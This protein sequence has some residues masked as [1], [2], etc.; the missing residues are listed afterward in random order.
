MTQPVFRFAPSPNGELHCGHALSALLNFQAARH[1]DGRFLLRI[2]DIDLGRARDAYV[3]QIFDDLSW[4]GLIWEEPVRRQS[5]HMHEYAGAVD[6][7]AAMGLTYPCFCTRQEIAAAASGS[8]P[9][10][11]PS[12][13]GTCRHL[14]EA[15][16]RKATANGTPFA[17]R[18]DMAAALTRIGRPL[19]FRKT[20]LEAGDEKQVQADPARWGDVVIA[21]K[22]VPTSYH[23][24][25]VFD[26]AL[27][28]V[29]HIV[30]GMDL[31]ASTDVHRV[32]QS[33]LKFPEPV[34]SHHRLILGEDGRKLA[35]S[36]PSQS[37]RALREGGATPADII[38]MV[39]LEPGT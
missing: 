27:Q 2:E 18:L 3:D 11:A 16:R 22:D 37:L 21:R 29:T 17:L 38:R 25:V 34:Y 24:S 23:L 39:R 15:A 35:K 30:R 14:G 36:R 6:K 10:G 28:G 32:L 7:L 13:P 31:F 5:E 19:S 4:L 8:D 12:Y 1:T 33:L 26:D 20:D 9:D